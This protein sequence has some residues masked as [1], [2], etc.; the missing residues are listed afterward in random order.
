MAYLNLDTGQPQA[1]LDQARRTPIPQAVEKPARA[2][3]P[4]AGMAA[5]VMLI[6]AMI[7]S[8]FGLLWRE[9]DSPGIA[10]IVTTSLLLPTAPLFAPRR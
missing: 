8:M 2:W 4:I 3:L 1:A 5:L 7:L 10:L 9:L 6:A